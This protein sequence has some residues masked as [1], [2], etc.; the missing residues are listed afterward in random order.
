MD[1]LT[2]YSKSE[3]QID[4]LIQTTHTFSTDLGINLESRNAGC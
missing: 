3:E 1:D 2:L 4:S